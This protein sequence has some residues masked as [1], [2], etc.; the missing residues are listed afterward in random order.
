MLRLKRLI[1]LFTSLMLLA[2]VFPVFSASPDSS[3][4][5]PNFSHVNDAPRHNRAREELI[6]K[7]WKEQCNTF[8]QMDIAGRRSDNLVCRIQ[9]KSE[10][11]IVIGAHYDKLQAGFGVA[12]NWSGIVILDALV[13]HF[14]PLSK[15]EFS[16]EFVA[17]TGEELGLIGSKSYL[18]QIDRKVV[19]MINLD[20]IGLRPLIIAVESDP[21]L[22]ELAKQIATDQGIETSVKGWKHITGDFETF[23][24][25]GIPALGL[26][27][28]DR[29]T[30]K[31]IHRRR[32]RSGVVDLELLGDTFRLS[33]ALVQKLSKAE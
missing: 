2:G 22:A 32:D 12:D 8:Y 16:L 14:Q 28:V 15:P 26:H 13:K 21:K 4:L 6:T 20:T 3:P 11:T 30:I 5:I 10:D 29:S 25:A 7:W 1:R 19:A 24:E 31:Q 27:S 9:G 33:V 18:K 17:F 23:M